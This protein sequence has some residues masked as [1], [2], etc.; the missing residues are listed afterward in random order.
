MC[1]ALDE[2]GYDAEDAEGEGEGVAVVDPVLV[3]PWFGDED[4]GCPV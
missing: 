4:V 2:A 1:P 3:T